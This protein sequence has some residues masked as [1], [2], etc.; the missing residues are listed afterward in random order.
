MNQEKWKELSREPVDLDACHKA[1]Q[2]IINREHTM[3]VPPR[4]DDADILLFRCIR[5]LR[6]LRELTMQQKIDNK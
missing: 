6:E 2:Q 5:E 3:H 4:I 1:L